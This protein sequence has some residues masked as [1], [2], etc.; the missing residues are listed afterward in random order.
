MLLLLSA[1]ALV[2]TPPGWQAPESAHLRNI[3]QLT[4]DFVR[5]GEGYFSPDMKQIVFQAEDRE[6]GNPFYQIFVMDLASGGYRRVSPGIGRTTCS[7]FRPDGK[8]II[9]ASSHTDPEALKHQADEYRRRA[10]ERRAGR[11]RNYQWDFDPY[12]AI[13]EANPDGS[14]LKRLTAAHGY[15]AEGS[16]SADG[17]QIVF[18]SNRDGNLQLYVMNADGGNV[19]KLTNTPGCYNGGPFFSPD[20]RRVIFRSDRKKKDYL[21][22]YVIN[23][24][25][26]GERALTDDQNS[27]NWGP[28]WFKDGK[29]IVYASADHSNPTRRPNYDLWWLN[30]ETGRKVRLTYA[31]AADVLPVF[32]PDGSKLMWTSTRDGR[33]SSQLYIADFVPPTDE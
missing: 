11:H 18:C 22:L 8:K 20:G 14:G 27:V 21:Q 17:R 24:D 9:F 3:R 32:S 16:Y 33:Q 1:L 31:P 30:V 2:D 13:Y 12:M 23:A 5:A 19:R 15:N 4:H 7:F 29:H 26:S 6:G 10:D 28:Y 25:G